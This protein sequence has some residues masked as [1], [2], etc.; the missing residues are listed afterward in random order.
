MVSMIYEA[1]K[2]LLFVQLEM[3]SKPTAPH[4]CENQIGSL[5]NIP[6]LCYLLF[7][8]LFQ[9]SAHVPIRNV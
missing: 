3:T 6:L 5:T 8:C 7:L 2:G 1:G 9:D 4:P